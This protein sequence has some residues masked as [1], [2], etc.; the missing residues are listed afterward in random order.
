MNHDAPLIT[1]KQSVTRVGLNSLQAQKLYF[2]KS[3]MKTMIIVFFNYHGRVHNEFA[4]KDQNVNWTFYKVA[5]D[6]LLKWIA[7]VCADLH[8]KSLEAYR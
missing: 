1:L 7:R 2:L 4:P 8:A 6:Q 3:K 5:M